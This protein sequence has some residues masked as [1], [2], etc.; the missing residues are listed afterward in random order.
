MIHLS[1]SR[2]DSDLQLCQSAF[3]SL[4]VHAIWKV[5]SSTY[6][7]RHSFHLQFSPP[8][9]GKSLKPASLITPVES[10]HNCSLRN[11]QCI[12]PVPS[13]TV[14]C[15]HP[16]ARGCVHL[17]AQHTASVSKHLLVKTEGCIQLRLRLAPPT[18]T[19]GH[20][21]SRPQRCVLVPLLVPEFK[22]TCS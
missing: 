14:E 12:H 6:F 22:T 3:Y 8:A 1:F 7:G 17:P 16:V 18:P 13:S 21:S 9:P 2:P 20:S 11:L 4:K 19:L 5:L 15:K 10:Q